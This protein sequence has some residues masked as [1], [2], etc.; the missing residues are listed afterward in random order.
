MQDLSLDLHGYTWKE[1][2]EEFI[3]LYN[4]SL[5]SKTDADPITI[6]VIHGYGSTGEGGKIRAQL[7]AFLQRFDARLE[8]VAGEDLDGNQGC[9]YV[10]PMKKLPEA[11]DRL[12]EQIWE[13]CAAAKSKGKISQ[14]FRRHG[15]PKIER[16]I[17]SLESQGRLHKRRG[18]KV[19]LF[20]AT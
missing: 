11:V 10:T 9:T 1:A 17:K 19:G 14:R 4:G 8:F 5:D 3:S 6:T 16:A 15:D 12:A 2:L 13:Y 20:Q 18:N 7:R